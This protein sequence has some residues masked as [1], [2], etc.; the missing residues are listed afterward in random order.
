MQTTSQAVRR[1]RLLR[2]IRIA[3]RSDT[4]G[5]HAARRGDQD[6]LELCTLAKISA[7]D[8]AAEW[9][10]LLGGLAAVW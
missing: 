10:Y 6:M 7:D 2:Y 4:L 5:F 3:H 9:L 1:T 8:Q